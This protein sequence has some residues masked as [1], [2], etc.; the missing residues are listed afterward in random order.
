MCGQNLPDLT[1]ARNFRCQINIV[2]K[3]KFKTF[4]QNIIVLNTDHTQFHPE[5]LS[6]DI[7][8]LISIIIEN[9]L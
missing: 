1:Q 2:E 5:F 8:I 7:K 4:L 3:R 6:E 9:F